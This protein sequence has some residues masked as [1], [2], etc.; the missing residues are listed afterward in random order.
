VS[1]KIVVPFRRPHDED[2]AEL[3]IPGHAVRLAP[4]GEMQGG[5]PPPPRS[6]PTYRQ[7]AAEA[8]AAE[9]DHAAEL[10]VPGAAP[11]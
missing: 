1:A 7:V 4:G 2:A 6:T 10:R 8:A 5:V 11:S 9:D 3:R